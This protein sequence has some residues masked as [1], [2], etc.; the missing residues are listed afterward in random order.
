MR[1]TEIAGSNMSSNTAISKDSERAE[2]RRTSPRE[3]MKHHVV[4]VFF[5]EDNW[6]KLTNM[7][8][9]GMAFEFAKPPSLEERVDFTFQAM[10]CMPMPRDGKALGDSFEAPG[11]IVWTR[12]FERGAGVQFVDLAEASRE[13]IRQWL[14]FETSANGST[15]VGEAKPEGLPTL[16]EMLAPVGAKS[17]IQSAADK[18]KEER[19]KEGLIESDTPKPHATRLREAEAAFLESSSA[20]EPSQEPVWSDQEAATAEP[21]V[22]QLP[23]YSHPSVARL[24]FLV[25][26]GCLAAF[27]V[28]VGARIYMTRT[29]QRADSAV[30]ASEPAPGMGEPTAEANA[31][32]A[33]SVSPPVSTPVSSVGAPVASSLSSRVS[34]QPFQVGVL[35]ADGRSWILWFVRGGAKDKDKD[36][37]PSYRPAEL[38]NSSGSPAT[39]TKRSEAAAPGKPKVTHTFD[40]EAPNVSH[41]PISNSPDKPAAEGPA[42]QSELTSSSGG[43]LDGA[44]GR[45]VAPAAPPAV[46]ATTGGMVQQPRLIR[47]APPVYPQFARSTQASGEVVVDALIDTTGKVTAV[48]VI[49]GPV[50]LRQAAMETVRQWKYE[51][52]RLDGQ[53]VAMHLT[54][55][56]EFHLN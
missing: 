7:S 32:V 9:S 18:D 39:T 19:T 6:G 17:D 49:S 48:K 52:A 1:E 20:E 42:I 53:A 23:S 41:S 3:K 21:V 34:A 33:N 37:S 30:H 45:Q 11:K 46:P 8:E 4:L 36:N 26:S 25:V 12:E 50:L 38:S 31:P 24:T 16:E 22:P 2:E 27:A 29:A 5:G 44:L 15:P 35:D 51:P 47:S 14:S 28:T 54:V 43:A 55:K 10:G 13:Q 56:V 40:F